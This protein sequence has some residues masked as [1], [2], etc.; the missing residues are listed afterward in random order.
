MR[1]TFV[2]ISIALVTGCLQTRQT[3]SQ[4]VVNVA[5]GGGMG[6]VSSYAQSHESCWT[7]PYFGQPNR[8][9]P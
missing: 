5:V 2:L 7:G 6:Q 3:S 8:V 4:G 1:R 9:Q